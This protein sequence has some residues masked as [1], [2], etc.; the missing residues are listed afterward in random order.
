MSE[1]AVG[2]S[3]TIAEIVH[4]QFLRDD[5]QGDPKSVF[6]AKINAPRYEGTLALN[7]APTLESPIHSG[8]LPATIHMVGVD[9]FQLVPSDA[10][11][12]TAKALTCKS[13]FRPTEFFSLTL[14]SVPVAVAL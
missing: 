12:A 5:T 7:N 11:R 4:V 6:S 9:D 8:V 14:G 10:M 3:H 1:I 13:V 2:P